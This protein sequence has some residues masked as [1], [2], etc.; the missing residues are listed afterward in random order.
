MEN[1]VRENL[2]A[3]RV[4]ADELRFYHETARAHGLTLSQWLRET[5]RRAAVRSQSRKQP[6]RAAAAAG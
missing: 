4:T 5:A 3:A 6:A 2:L 1:A